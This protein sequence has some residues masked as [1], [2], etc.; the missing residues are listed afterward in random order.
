[1]L[2]FGILPDFARNHRCFLLLIPSQSLSK[3]VVPSLMRAFCSE[4]PSFSFSKRIFLYKFIYWW[5]SLTLSWFSLETFWKRF[6]LPSIKSWDD[7]TPTLN[8]SLSTAAFK[9]KEKI[10]GLAVSGLTWRPTNYPLLKNLLET[11]FL[12]FTLSFTKSS[13]P[14]CVYGLWKYL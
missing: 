4:T 2:R 1:M 7:F 3:L 9:G 8:A 6:L 10:R 14:P 12:K 13:Y 11:I 5:T